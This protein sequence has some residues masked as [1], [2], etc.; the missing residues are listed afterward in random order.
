M[1]ALKEYARLESI[2]VWQENSAVQRRDVVVSF[3]DSTLVISDKNNVALTH[4]SLAAIE[5][6]NPGETPAIFSPGDNDPETL[7]IAED[8]MVEAVERVRTLI[9]RRRAKPGRLR[10]W[11]LG[12]SILGVLALVFL[13]VPGALLRHTVSV[14]PDV[15]RSEIGTGLLTSVTRISGQPCT[16]ARGS[17]ALNQLSNRLLGADGGGVLV[18]PAAIQ[19]ALHLPGDI[20]LLSKDVIED[21]ETPEVAAGFVLAETLRREAADPIEN[22]L[23]HSGMLTTFKLL[24]TGEIS[25]DDLGAYAEVLLSEQPSV[26]EDD[27]LIARFAQ[28]RVPTT[29]YA[30]AIDVTGE[31]TIPLIEADPMRNGGAERVLSDADWVSLQVICQE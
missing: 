9:A 21:Y 23:A 18:L 28:A 12:A 4:W 5:R 20:I 8:T 10:M 27:A 29:P 17:Q 16:S 24:T 6:V 22:L 31:N 3:G 19:G 26:L 30:Y 11:L 7:E 2:G 14:L 1:T 15:T 25:E 13:W